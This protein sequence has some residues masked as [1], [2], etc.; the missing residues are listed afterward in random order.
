MFIKCILEW[1][2]DSGSCCTEQNEDRAIKKYSFDMAILSRHSPVKSSVITNSHR[3]VKD[4]FM[5]MLPIV[6]EKDAAFL[7]FI[8]VELVL[9]PWVINCTCAPRRSA[10][11]LLVCVL[12][13]CLQCSKHNSIV[14]HAHYAVYEKAHGVWFPFSGTL[15]SLSNC[16]KCQAQDRMTGEFTSLLAVVVS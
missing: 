10:T 15:P 2:L 14:T 13:D 1:V 12:R 16:I 6:L 3:T 9:C 11:D 7:Y 4:L 8:L 5:W